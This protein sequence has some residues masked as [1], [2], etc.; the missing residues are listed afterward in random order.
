MAL[1]FSESDETMWNSMQMNCLKRA[2]KAVQLDF[3][4]S[5]SL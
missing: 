3:I 4:I 5:H 1:D 2:R